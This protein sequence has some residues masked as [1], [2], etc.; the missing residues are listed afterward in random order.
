MIAAFVA[1]GFGYFWL[2]F[3]MIIRLEFLEIDFRKIALWFLVED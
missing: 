3:R 1:L 2:F